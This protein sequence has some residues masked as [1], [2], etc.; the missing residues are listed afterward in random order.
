MIQDSGN[1]TK[2]ETG[3]VRDMGEGKGRCDLLPPLA[4]LRLAKHFEAGCQKYG[5]Q[6]ETKPCKS[7]GE[8]KLIEDFSKDKSKHDG[9]SIYCRQCCKQ[10]K[11]RK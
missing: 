2:F 5:L 1:R 4:L 8:K 11:A 3:A 10:K 9:L 6:V 7:C